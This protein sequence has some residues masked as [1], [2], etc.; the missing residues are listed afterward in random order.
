MPEKDGDSWSLSHWCP[1]D[2]YLYIKDD[3]RMNFQ[4]DIDLTNI[5]ITSQSHLRDS[6]IQSKGVREE[7]D[8]STRKYC[9]SEVIIYRFFLAFPIP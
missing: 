9:S 5:S 7:E 1:C 3:I 2:N 8:Q 6:N 4:I